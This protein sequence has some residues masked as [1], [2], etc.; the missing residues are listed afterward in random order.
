[1]YTCIQGTEGKFVLFYKY[2]IVFNAI[3]NIC[4]QY[5]STLSVCIWFLF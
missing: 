5:R 3:K 2:L 4:E 1:M